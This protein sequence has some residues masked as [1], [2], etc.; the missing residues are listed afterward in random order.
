VSEGIVRQPVPRESALAAARLQPHYA[1]L[2]QQTGAARLGMWLFLASEVLLFSALFGLYAS[3][4]AAHHEI[5]AQAVRLTNAR[6]GAAMTVVLVTSSLAVALALAALRTERPRQA[7]RWLGAAIALGGGFLVLKGLE[8]REHLA[9]GLRPGLGYAFPELPDP[10]ANE[11]FTLYY[12]MTGLHALHVIGGLIV[13]VVLARWLARQRIDAVYQTPLELGALYWHLV[14][15]IWLFL[16]PM[17][18]LMH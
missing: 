6:S 12:V 11:F 14:D 13:L 9:A 8:Y 1:N 18:Y 7:L 5:F 10:A 17:F 3:Y 4:R 2:E 16:W 15:A